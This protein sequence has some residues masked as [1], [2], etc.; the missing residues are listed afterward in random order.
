[1]QRT[2]LKQI[3]IEFDE[4]GINVHKPI[5]E[6]ILAAARLTKK[7]TAQLLEP[8]SESITTIVDTTSEV[9]IEMLPESPA[10]TMVELTIT[11]DNVPVIVAVTPKKSRGFQKKIKPIESESE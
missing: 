1:M 8:V 5:T 11:S 4:L 10:L 6:K 2:R 7:E 9:A 3:Q